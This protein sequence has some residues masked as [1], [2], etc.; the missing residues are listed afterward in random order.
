MLRDKFGHQRLREGKY[1][2][3]QIDAQWT[4]EIED[5]FIQWLKQNKDQLDVPRAIIEELI[6]ERSNGGN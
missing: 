1:T 2:P 6:R 5:D 4:K 3:G